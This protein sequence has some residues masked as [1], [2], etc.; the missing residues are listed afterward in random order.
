MFSHILV[1]TDGSPRADRAVDAAMALGA[2]AGIGAQ[3]T[4][5]TVVRPAAPEIFGPISVLEESL[6]NVRELR[7][8]WVLAEAETRALALGFRTDAIL[9]VAPEPT[10]AILDEAER[11]GCDLIVVGARGDACPIGGQAVR[12]VSESAIPVM[13]AR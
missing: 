6:D 12:V 2:G 9:V 8:E 5:L 13:I 3:L 4:F 7:A 11:R 1:A 10:R